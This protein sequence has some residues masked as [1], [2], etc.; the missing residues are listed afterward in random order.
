MYCRKLGGDET[1]SFG[2]KLEKHDN[3]GYS[4]TKMLVPPRD[5]SELI[6]LVQLCPSLRGVFLNS[7]E[8][9]ESKPP[10]YNV[11]QFRCIPLQQ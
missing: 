9:P 8:S 2:L 11:F 6:N 3:T 5:H 1:P 7:L 4:R 10:V